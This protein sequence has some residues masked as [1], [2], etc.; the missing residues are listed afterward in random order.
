MPAEALCFL[1][2]IAVDF[3]SSGH[4]LIFTHGS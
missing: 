3:A 2:K 4:S 1:D